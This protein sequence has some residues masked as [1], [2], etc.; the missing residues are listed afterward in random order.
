M[1]K[2]TL[3]WIQIPIVRE[4]YSNMRNYDPWLNKVWLEFDNF[5]YKYEYCSS[6]YKL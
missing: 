1:L 2:K 6:T 3:E 5:L 4:Y